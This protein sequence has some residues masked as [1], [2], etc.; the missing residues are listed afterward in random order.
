MT[1]D[2]IISALE[3][4]DMLQEKYGKLGENK[5]VVVEM[6]LDDEFPL[7]PW[8]KPENLS[9][10]LVSTPLDIKRLLVKYKIGNRVLVDFGRKTKYEWK[11]EGSP[12]DWS[13]S[14]LGWMKVPE[15]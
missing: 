4:Y 5:R 8:Q 1:E 7:G 14:I 9:E 6:L 12:S 10:D 15:V 3:Y 2:K 11:V 13:D